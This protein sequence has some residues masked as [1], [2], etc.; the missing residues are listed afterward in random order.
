MCSKIYSDNWQSRTLFFYFIQ[1]DV[2]RHTERETDKEGGKQRCRNTEKQI[3]A[4]S[5]EGYTDKSRL[6]RKRRT[7]KHAWENPDVKWEGGREEV[8]KIN[9]GIQPHLRLRPPVG[10]WTPVVWQGAMSKMPN[11]LSCPVLLEQFQSV[12][13]DDVQ[14]APSCCKAASSQL[15][16]CPS[17]FWNQPRMQWW[18]WECQNMIIFPWSWLTWVCCWF[19]SML[20]SRY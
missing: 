20:N 9:L 8:K 11:A 4:L 3:Q 14:K 5:S 12:S 2:C 7:H 16:V 18:F 6:L 17:G 1:T 13:P 10:T 15:D 19:A